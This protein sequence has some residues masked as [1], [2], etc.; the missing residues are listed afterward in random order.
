MQTLQA[1]RI[2]TVGNM[3]I[4]FDIQFRLDIRCSRHPKAD[5]SNIFVS[6]HVNL[7]P[8]SKDRRKMIGK[9]G[10]QLCKRASREAGSKKYRILRFVPVKVE[11]LGRYGVGREENPNRIIHSVWLFLIH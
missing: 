4:D 3:G 7:V 11:R 9:S 2:L 1:L 10:C 6:L 8:A 5:A